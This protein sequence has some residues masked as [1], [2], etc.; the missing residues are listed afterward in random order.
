MSTD[1]GSPSTS[2]EERM[3]AL[4]NTM[5][6]MQRDLE[7][8]F[9]R[10]EALVLANRPILPT[11]P[12][13]NFGGVHGRSPTSDATPS[14]IHGGLPKPKLEAPKTDGTDPLRWLYKTSVMEY[15]TAFENVLQHVTDASES[16]LISVF[17]SGLKPHLQHEISLLA[18]E[19]LSDSFALARELEA[20]HMALIRSVQSRG[21]SWPTSQ[22]PRT[23]PAGQAPHGQPTTLPAVATDPTK[24][25][26]TPIHRL[27]RAEKLEKDAKGLCYNCDQRWTK[28]HRCRRVLLLIGDDD[29]APDLEIDEP[30]TLE[31][32]CVTADISSLQTLTGLS[33]PRSLRLTGQICTHAIH[34]L[35]DGGS[36]H[37]FIHPSVAAK[38]QVPIST[39]PP[40]RVYVDCVGRPVVTPLIAHDYAKL[41]MEFSWKGKKVLLRGDTMLPR[42]VN[43]QTFVAMHSVGVPAAYLEVFYLG[44][45]S[46]WSSTFPAYK[47]ELPAGSQIHPVFHVSH[48][49]PYTGRPDDLQGQP[50]PA[51]FVHGNPL[52]TPLRV[53]AQRTVLRDGRA[54]VQGLVEWTDGNLDDASWEPLQPLLELF[55]DLHLEDKVNFEEGESVT[56]GVS[57]ET[58]HEYED[59][60]TTTEPQEVS[61]II[62]FRTEKSKEIY[63]EVSAI[64]H[65]RPYAVF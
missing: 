5:H 16:N 61:A 17:H 23:T 14:G 55:L 29:D 18:P 1:S 34:I 27:T 8:K 40:F 36:T 15:Q 62:I 58:C 10:L 49:K 22:P 54:E 51:E 65:A 20:K 63:Q 38:L 56:H 9:A 39:V 28:G 2:P 44:M 30:T 42:G 32:P 25:F 33:T 45:D 19:T 43:L 57:E 50:L 7:S 13:G 26:P 4:Q 11:P 46:V 31:E 48:L 35:I 52:S 59:E 53:H 64:I 12:H 60:P 47:L 6:Q 21:P 41:T 24:V 3:D 37:N